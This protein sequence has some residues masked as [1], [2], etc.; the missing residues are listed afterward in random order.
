[1]Y[2]TISDLIKDL[3]GI[4]IPLPI[5]TFGFFVALAFMAA[6]YVFVQELKRKEKSG[7]LSPT[8]RTVTVGLPAT[9]QELITNALFGFLIGFKILYI[10]FNYSEFANDPASVIISAKGNFIGGIIVGAVA[11]YLAYREKK[12]QQLDKPVTKQELVHPYQWMGNILVIAAIS[13][14]IGAKIFHNLENWDE[15]MRNPIEGL[16]SFSGLTFYGG[17]IV[18]AIAVLWYSSKKGIPVVHMLDVSAPGMMLSYAIG[19]IGCQLAGDGD[20]GIVNNHPKP[21]WMGF[22]PDWM[23][24]YNYPHNVLNEGI[25]IPG[26]AGNHCNMLPEPVYP[27]P[28]YE[29]VICLLLFGVLWSLRKRIN[30]PGMIFSIYLIL[31]GLERFFIEKIRVNTL[32][33]VAGKSFTQA[34]LISSIMV[35]G[36]IVGIILCL[37]NKNKFSGA[38]NQSERNS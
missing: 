25:P 22:L 10:I 19:R 4:Y 8:Y 14:I 20:W 12:K 18:G 1:M 30:I 26:C 9:T 11:A 31:N 17:L 15:F 36:G 27:T 35:I 2:P 6:Y 29:V 24:S 7:L 33:H 21:D 3:F 16:L 37:K 23:W 5:Q 38:Q 34:E 32:Y 28:F 13:G